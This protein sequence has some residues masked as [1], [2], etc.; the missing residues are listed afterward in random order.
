MKTSMFRICAILAIGLTA[1]LQTLQAQ[2]KSLLGIWD[3]SVTVAGFATPVLSSGLS[4]LSDHSIV[5]IQ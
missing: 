4:G 3:V 1:S 5:T 2:Q